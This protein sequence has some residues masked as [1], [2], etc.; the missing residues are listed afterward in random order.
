V[1][2]NQHGTL[3]TLGEQG[4]LITGPS[5]AGKTLLALALLR[6]CAACG[7]FARLVSDDQVF[8]SES[9]GR[10]IG[11]EAPA[12][13]GLAEA[14]G[15]GPAPLA[16]EPAVVI[17]LLVRLVLANAAPRYQETGMERLEG[18]DLPCLHLSE[19]NAESAT[20]A[21]AARLLLP[22]FG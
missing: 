8:L 15:F 20:M 5:G 4:V 19:R 17:D 6:H 11:R 9:G 2:A 14:R 13:G 21:I 3:L 18:V 22:P 10:L 1:A 16:H 7:R 12:I